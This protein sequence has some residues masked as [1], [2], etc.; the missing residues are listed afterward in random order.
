MKSFQQIKMLA[1]KSD[2]ARV[3][4][5]VG[6]SA[7]TVRMVVRQERTDLHNI[8]RVFTEFLELREKLSQREAKRR[9]RKNK[10]LVYE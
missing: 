7:S 9:S 2:Y 10:R 5:I 3:A 1:E 6:K 8:Q 4:E